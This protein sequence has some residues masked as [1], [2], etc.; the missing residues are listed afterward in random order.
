[1]RAM[2]WTTLC[3]GL[4]CMMGSA[5]AGQAQ[6][7]STATPVVTTDT[8][9][10]FYEAK[11]KQHPTLFAAHAALGAAY[12]DKARETHDV[13]WLA[14]GRNALNRSLELQPNLNALLSMAALCNFSHRF[15]CGLEFAERAERA[16]PGD[17]ALLPLRVEAQLGLGKL[18][19]AAKLIETQ[20]KRGEPSF[21]LLGA[22]GRW[23]A[24]QKRFDEA[25]DSF[26]AA[27][28]QGRKEESD[29]LVI[30]AETNAAGMLIDSKRGGEPAHT[31]LEKAAALKASSWPITA[32]LQ[33]HWAELHDLEGRPEQALALYKGILERQADPEIYRRAFVLAQKMGRKEE[34]ADLLA[35]GERAAEQVLAAGEIFALEAQARLYADA[36]IKLA[37]AEQLARQNLEQKQDRSA[38]ETLA[39]VQ[40][41]AAALR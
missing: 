3:A 39:Y 1:M 7:A 25:H 4:V 19:A 40:E 20:L 8:A 34:A 30:W 38:R 31:H 41:R 5:H 11:L 29:D 28:A 17:A 18:D 26:A 37:R 6:A 36:G 12:L 10:E 32:V 21:A 14:K 24:E 33:V 2:L 35:A 9:I 15:A 23:F 13:Q 22:Q 27:A 16:H